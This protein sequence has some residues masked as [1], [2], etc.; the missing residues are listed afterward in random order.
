VDEE[1]GERPLGVLAASLWCVLAVVVTHLTASL[2]DTLRPG[3]GND[4]VSVSLARAVAVVITLFGIARVHAPEE[5]LSQI[6][7]ADRT[8]AI[9]PR[10]A[11]FAIAIVMGL[12]ACVAL[13]YLDEQLA[14]RFPSPEESET[15]GKLLEAPMAK[16]MLFVASFAIVRPLSEELLFRGAL[17]T[18]LGKTRPIV[19][20]GVT[21]VLLSVLGD[22]FTVTDPRGMT[23]TLLFAV[24]VTYLRA[25]SGSV[26]VTIVAHVA[27]S[28]DFVLAMMRPQLAS[29]KIT[30][31]IGASAAA[32]T[33]ACLVVARL[34]AKGK[35]VAQPTT[36]R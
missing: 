24:A 29:L 6:L 33:L 1:E 26:V 23:E 5:S 20:A 8:A 11:F 21:A 12:A 10:A 13:E 25:M 35:P 17:F 34:V 27:F 32:V 9:K 7:G 36:E 18:G 28:A 3:A 4:L 22:P 15:V 31:P 30:A 2:L 16:R 19:D 14:A